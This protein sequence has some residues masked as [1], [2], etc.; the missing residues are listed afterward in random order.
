MISV[1]FDAVSE[2][3]ILWMMSAYNIN[4]LRMDDV[5]KKNVRLYKREKDWSSSYLKLGMFSFI[6]KIVISYT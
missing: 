4:G 2:S 5:R 3:A 1:G 6:P